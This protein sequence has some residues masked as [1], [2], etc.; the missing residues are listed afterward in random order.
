M[1][2]GQ[3]LELPLHDWECQLLTLERTDYAYRDPSEEGDQAGRTVGAE[4]TTFLWR[5]RLAAEK[6][7][8]SMVSA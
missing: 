8:V 1:Q 5:R 4:Q 6:A 7:C 2:L 3:C